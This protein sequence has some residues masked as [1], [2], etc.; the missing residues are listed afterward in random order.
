MILR[1][2][3]LFGILCSGPFLFFRLFLVSGGSCCPLLVPKVDLGLVSEATKSSCKKQVCRSFRNFAK[4]GEA[5]NNL[6]S[7]A[8]LVHGAP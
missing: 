5:Y 6:R 3:F 1:N 8:G 4:V 2:T 7:G